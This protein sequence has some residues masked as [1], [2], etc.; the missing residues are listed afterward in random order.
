MNVRCEKC[1]QTYDADPELA[2][3]TVQCQCGENIFVPEIKKE[4][5]VV[6]KAA[7]WIYEIGKVIVALG[8]IFTIFGIIAVCA[9]GAQK[10]FYPII[11]A[12]GTIGGVFM[13]GTGKTLEYLAEIA[14]NTRKQ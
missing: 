1:G 14:F 9:D 3:K 7:K 11:C 13:M 4:P 6:P 10:L 8:I 12:I 2:E 5:F